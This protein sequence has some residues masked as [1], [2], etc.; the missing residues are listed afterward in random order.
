MPF[1]ESCAFQSVERQDQLLFTLL[2][3]TV[4]HLGARCSV[5]DAPA[6]R[7]GCR[8]PESLMGNNHTVVEMGA[9]DGLHMANSFFFSKTLGWRALLVEGNPEVYRR[10]SLHRPEAERVNAL[11]G[12]PRDF[13]PDGKAPF[14]SFYRPGDS[15]KQ[16]TAR[17]W[18]T[19]LS[20]IPSPNSS[21]PALRS[22]PDAKRYA[23]RHGVQ[24][25]QHRL[26][27]V[28]FSTLLS[29]MFFD[30]IDV[31]FLDVEGAELSVLQ[32]LNFKKHPVRILVV[33][34][35]TPAV[36]QLLKARGYND[37]GF[38]YDSGGDR[39]FFGAESGSLFF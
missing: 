33:E 12:D 27:V 30:K 23:S 36:A 13:P 11:V 20:G 15:E 17:D 19:G 25:R 28:R 21:M 29:D 7:C 39:V 3:G 8:A 14:F 37:L 6:G 10:I 24:F 9:N 16:N 35:P 1:W 32:T 34:R 31:L 2:G 18:E 26:D 5:W 4:T 38:T 22:A